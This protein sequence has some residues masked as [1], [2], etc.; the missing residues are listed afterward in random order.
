MLTWGLINS[1]IAPWGRPPGRIE[2]REERP[3]VSRALT[4]IG[5]C[6]N[7][8]ANRF[9]RS[10]IFPLAGIKKVWHKEVI[11][12]NEHYR[13]K[14]RFRDH[15][16]LGPLQRLFVSCR[17][18]WRHL[19]LFSANFPHLKK[20]PLPYFIVEALIYLSINSESPRLPKPSISIPIE[21]HYSTTSVL[22]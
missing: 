9:R 20:P 8:S 17:P 6:G 22:Q 4:E 12:S 7:R 2:S 19:L 16:I 11:C 13:L 14:A 3:V 15:R 18:E 1:V 5:G 21:C 10:T